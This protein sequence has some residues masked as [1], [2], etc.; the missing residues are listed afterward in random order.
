[1]RATAWRGA[2]IV[3][4]RSPFPL[5]GLLLLSTGLAFWALLE[6]LGDIPIAVVVGRRAGTA[7][8]FS[9]PS[10]TFL[11]LRVFLLSSS[12]IDVGKRR[13]EGH[14]LNRQAGQE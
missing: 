8:L 12:G 13:D 1:L 7:T 10:L 6:R 9:L 3:V 5:W 4:I 11:L 2:G 14:W